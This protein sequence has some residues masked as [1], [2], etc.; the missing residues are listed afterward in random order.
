MNKNYK[1]DRKDVALVVVD[2]QD[3]LANAVEGKEEI[4]KQTAI[5]EKAANIFQIPVV[6][7]T[8]YKK[9]LGDINE[10][11]KSLV[12]DA[13]SFDKVHFSIVEEEEIKEGL[14]KLGKKQLIV[15]GM[16]THICI[17][18]S[19]IDLL[20]EGYEVFVPFDAVGSRE[21]KNKE[22]ALQLMSKM[23]AV[24]TNTESLLFQLLGKSTVPEFKEVQNLIK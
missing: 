16:E 15:T 17:L 13:L 11:L 14:K 20:K 10:E 24:I 3:S 8:Q 21:E 18:N 23:G 4:K 12:K 9:G 1:A 5:L 6:F 22:N 19:V 7:T 2:I